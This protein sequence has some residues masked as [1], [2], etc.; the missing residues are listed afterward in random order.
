MESI[1]KSSKQ[2]WLYLI[3]SSFSSFGVIGFY[4]ILS[5]LVKL[6]ETLS[7][8]ICFALFSV[9]FDFRHFFPTYLNTFGD[10]LYYQQNKNWLWV[11]LLFIV[12]FPLLSFG[13]LMQGQVIEYN[14]QLV[15][16][17][18]RRV[19]LLIGFYH[20]IAQQ[21]RFIELF[22]MRFREPQDDSG[23]WEKRMLFVG[24][25]IPLIY[26]AKTHLIWFNDENAAFT[27]NSNELNYVLEFW[28]EIALFCLII[29]VF[30]SLIGF[31]FS[32]E[33][34][35]K[36][37]A[38]KCCYL[39]VGLFGLIKC[40]LNYGSD[41]VLYVFLLV[42]TISF[43]FCLLF[44]VLKAFQFR[45]FNRKKWF[46]FS[47][48]LVI[49]AVVLTLPL[50]HKAV[51]LLALAVPHAIQQLVFSNQV[52]VRYYSQ[53]TEKHGFA[54]F[55]ARKSLWMMVFTFTFAILLEW[56]RTVITFNFM[57]SPDG[58]VLKNAFGIL[59]FSFLL[60]HYFLE[61]QRWNT[62]AHSVMN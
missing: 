48:I 57:D 8:T 19:T 29:G 17:F 33:Y 36:I 43:F 4:F 14:S 55:L 47:S 16:V 22:K 53:S 13:I 44:V 15:F 37:I 9:L 41:Q 27:P 2:D 40:V 18:A 26:L 52:A 10:R 60:V 30:F 12:L 46:F 5:N 62:T 51:L 59:F 35:L 24:S 23:I 3:L 7:L 39:L 28:S 38:R 31:V 34:R 42:L 54:A 61:A 45:K 56:G 6:D 11:S 25:F 49:N 50:Q 58:L 1:L 21:W 32:V 20:L